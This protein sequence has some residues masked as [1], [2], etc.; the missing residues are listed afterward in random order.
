M[1]LIH[2]YAVPLSRCGSG[3]LGLFHSPGVK[4]SPLVPLRYPQE[5]AGVRVGAPT[6]RMSFFR[7]PSVNNITLVFFCRGRRP[8]DPNVFFRRP[9]VNNITLVFLVGV[10]APDDPCVLPFADDL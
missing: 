7:R 1:L 8:D 10:G 5:K 9:S 6:T 4:F 2:R 3:T